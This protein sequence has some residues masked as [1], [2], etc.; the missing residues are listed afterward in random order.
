MRCHSC[1]VRLSAVWA[2]HFRPPACKSTRRA[3]GP[4]F[5]DPTGLHEAHGDAG[6][7]SVTGAQ[8]KKCLQIATSETVLKATR[9]PCAEATLATRSRLGAEPH[10]SSLSATHSGKPSGARRACTPATASPQSSARTGPRLKPAS[11]ARRLAA[12]SA[13]RVPASPGDR[14]ERFA[15]PC[16]WAEIRQEGRPGAQAVFRSWR[17]VGAS[18]GCVHTRRRFVLRLE[19]SSGRVCPYR[20]PR[21]VAG[22]DGS[23]A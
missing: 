2:A 20:P 6:D 14:R 9:L 3:D 17:V 10:A 22:R 13:S 1:T 7:M 11:P 21:R 4:D 8:E 18:F 12:R 16:E 19:A 15:R 23:D 5:C